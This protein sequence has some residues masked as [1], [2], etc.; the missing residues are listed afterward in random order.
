M[1]T[2]EA[3][4]ATICIP[5]QALN[6]QKKK[7]WAS[8]SLPGS[9]ILDSCQFSS[10]DEENVQCSRCIWYKTSTKDMWHNSSVSSWLRCWIDTK[11]SPILVFTPPTFFYIVHYF[12]LLYYLLIVA[13]WCVTFIRPRPRITFSTKGMCKGTYVCLQPPGRCSNYN[14]MCFQ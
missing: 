4:Q 7:R 1:L 8:L 11:L 10:E 12:K 6:W 9:K 5:K 13:N 2:T 14:L 3:Q